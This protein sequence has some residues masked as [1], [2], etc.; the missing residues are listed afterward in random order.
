VVD[1][2]GEV[3]GAVLPVCVTRS[4]DVAEVEIV[5]S[6]W[7]VIRWSLTLGDRLAGRAQAGAKC[8]L[9]MPSPDGPQLTVRNAIG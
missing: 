5:D 8:D 4:G 1:D 9:A 6:G 2:R 7:L 3:A